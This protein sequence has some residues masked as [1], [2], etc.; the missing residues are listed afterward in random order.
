MHVEAEMLSFDMA[1]Y[2]V[3]SFENEWFDKHLKTSTSSIKCGMTST[4]S[5]SLYNFMRNGIVR[6]SSSCNFIL[7]P[8]NEA[9][10]SSCVCPTIKKG[11]NTSL[12]ILLATS[13]DQ[14][15]I[16]TYSHLLLFAQ[17]S[18]WTCIIGSNCLLKR[19][20]EGGQTY[21]LPIKYCLTKRRCSR[22]LIQ[23]TGQRYWWVFNN[24]QKF[25]KKSHCMIDNTRVEI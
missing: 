10:M 19:V 15:H 2:V 6:K 7:Q 14:K 21:L 9:S 16:T 8:P 3:T 13:G 25:C 4:L 1:N 22:I 11:R 17:L 18:S 23:S 20:N 5:K 12:K 24:S